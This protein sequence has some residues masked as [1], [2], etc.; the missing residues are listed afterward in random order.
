MSDRISV[1]K[2]WGREHRIHMDGKRDMWIMEMHA[3]H[4][5]SLHRHPRKDKI[6]VVLSGV[7]SMYSDATGWQGPLSL[8]GTQMVAKGV[9]HRQVAHED[10]E[11]LEIECPPAKGD[12]ER[13]ADVY[14]RAGMPYER[15]DV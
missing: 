7:V 6:L 2:P 11:I 3:G 12:I 8:F 14:G 9:L 13:V 15:E 10:A 5:S 4:G 1:N